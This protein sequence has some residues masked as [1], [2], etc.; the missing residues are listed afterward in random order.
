MISL[1][2]CIR[3]SSGYLAENEIDQVLVLYSAAN[4]VS[5]TNLF[6]LSK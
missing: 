5:D 3:D 4:F 2:M 1:Q 6:V